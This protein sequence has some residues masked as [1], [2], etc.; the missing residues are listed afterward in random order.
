MKPYWSPIL[1][2]LALAGLPAQ[3]F[4]AEEL[5]DDQMDRISA[6]GDPVVV[7]VS[8]ASG[9]TAYRSS[10]KYTLSLS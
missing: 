10:P 3:S 2:S 7:D 1:V 9:S 5:Q 6:S 4:G 8:G